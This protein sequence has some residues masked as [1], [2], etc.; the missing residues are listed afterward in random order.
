MKTTYVIDQDALK[1]LKLNFNLNQST[2]TIDYF[3]SRTNLIRWD[4]SSDKFIE[5]NGLIDV[6]FVRET[7]L[8]SEEARKKATA[9]N[10]IFLVKRIFLGEFFF[11]TL[12]KYGKIYRVTAED[13]KRKIPLIQEYHI[14]FED[15]IENTPVYRYKS[16]FYG[17]TFD[18]LVQKQVDELPEV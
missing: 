3:I 13:I 17:N 18:Y 15:K 14:V 16:V 10:V 2:K 11:D 9:K 4:V 12:N 7:I 8:S 1:K 5:L 6:S